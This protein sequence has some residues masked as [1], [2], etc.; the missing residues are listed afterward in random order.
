MS[1]AS[2][3]DTQADLN[4]MMSEILP[5]E[6]P[7]AE[8]PAPKQEVPGDLKA[9]VKDHES[10]YEKQKE[11]VAQFKA[12]NDLQGE[13]IAK[14]RAEVSRWKEAVTRSDAEILALKEK[15]LGLAGAGALQETLVGSL[16][17]EIL[18]MQRKVETG[19]EDSAFSQL[20]VI[21]LRR[22]ICELK[23]ELEELRAAGA[24]EKAEK[25]AYFGQL[26]EESRK[27]HSIVDANIRFREEG[28]NLVL[29]IE[30]MKDEMRN[31]R[32]SNEEALKFIM[33]K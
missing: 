16:R 1:R 18:L 10:C 13:D 17:R 12:E 30:N 31:L 23:G 21:R 24:R 4:Q 5:A 28:K 8:E 6:E 3:K 20:E 25:E 15:N 22:E 2:I 29:L 11:L 7:V 33:N 14:L 9:L 32:T 27:H 26:Q 19:H